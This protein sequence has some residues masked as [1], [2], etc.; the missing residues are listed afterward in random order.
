MAGLVL[1]L[2][3]Q[4]PSEEEPRA[5]KSN[6]PGEGGAPFPTSPPMDPPFDVTLVS[7]VR[8]T[9]KQCMHSRSNINR[10]RNR[11]SYRAS[12]CYNCHD[13]HHCKFVK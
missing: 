1:L 2:Q 8:G 11:W 12:S 13:C 9:A 5:G 4:G 10:N 3:V 6:R 7:Q